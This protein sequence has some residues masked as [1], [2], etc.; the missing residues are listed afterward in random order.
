MRRRVLRAALGVVAAGAIVSCGGGSG[1]S[2]SSGNGS[3]PE[4]SGPISATQSA[5]GNWLANPGFE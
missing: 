3:T 2:G 1:G 4:P 5:D